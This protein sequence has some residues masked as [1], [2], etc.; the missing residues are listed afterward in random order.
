MINAVL[1]MVKHPMK[2]YLLWIILILLFC[3]I[4]IPVLSIGHSGG[5]QVPLILL[6]H[7]ST[8]TVFGLIIISAVSPIIYWRWYKKYYFVPMV[9]PVFL[10]AFLIYL[11]IDIYVKNGN[12]FAW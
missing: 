7:A 2:V 6:G 12:Y 5:E 9:I 4:G 11:I 10:G 1:K 3:I 8:I